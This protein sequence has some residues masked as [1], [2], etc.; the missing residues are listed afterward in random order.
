MLFADLSNSS[1]F[2]Q[3]GRNRKYFAI[4][5]KGNEYLLIFRKSFQERWRRLVAPK[6]FP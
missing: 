3:I 2:Y 4:F 5:F 1:E 6:Y